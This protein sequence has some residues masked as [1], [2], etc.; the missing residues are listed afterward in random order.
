MRLLQERDNSCQF[1]NKAKG[2]I[3]IKDWEHGISKLL[4]KVR[5]K[6]QYCDKTQ[7]AIQFMPDHLPEQFNRFSDHVSIKL[8]VAGNDRCIVKK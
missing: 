3:R 6:T 8:D 1:L 5:G 7:I 2:D 4:N